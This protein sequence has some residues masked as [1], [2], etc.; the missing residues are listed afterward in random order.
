MFTNEIYKA[1]Q[2]FDK[3]IADIAKKYGYKKK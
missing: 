2:E 3:K 1:A